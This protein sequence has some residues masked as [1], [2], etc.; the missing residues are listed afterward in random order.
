MLYRFASFFP[1][2][3]LARVLLF[4]FSFILILTFRA[5]FEN[6]F[7]FVGTFC[8]K[9]VFSE[10][11]YPIESKKFEKKISRRKGGAAPKGQLRPFAIELKKIQ[12]P[13][14]KSTRKV[15]T[16]LHL[17]CAV[18]FYSDWLL[19]F[20]FTFEARE[21]LN[22]PP[23]PSAPFAG[24]PLRGGTIGKSLGNHHKIVSIRKIIPTLV[25]L[26]AGINV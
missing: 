5:N 26:L 15:A 10:I 7:C 11:S 17:D 4:F 6:K 16:Y 20:T 13:K 9:F 19:P 22:M 18:S 25:C 23:D 3:P 24:G 8:T 14:K 1:L 21:K 2:I 12:E